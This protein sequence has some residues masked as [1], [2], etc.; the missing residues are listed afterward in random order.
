MVEAI[1][2]EAPVL[3]REVET[4]SGHLLGFA[5]LNAPKSLNAL[6]LDM[7]RLLDPQLRRW[8]EDPRVA[9]VILYGSGEKAFCAGGDIRSLHSSILKHGATPLN[10]HAL[11]FFT[12]EYG[13]DYRIHTYAKPV[14]VWASGICMGGGIGLL[15]GASHRVVTETTRLAMPEISIGFF[16]DVGGSWFL[17]KMPGRMGLFVALTGISFNGRDAKVAGLADYFASSAD[18][19]ALFERLAATRWRDATGAN[20]QI[21]SDELAMLEPPA[22]ALLPA[23]NLL[24]RAETI[25]RLCAGDSLGDIVQRI[26]NV[27]GNDDW[28]QRGARTL[29][30]GSP[31]AVALTWELQRRARKLSLADVFCLELIVALQCCAH[32][33]FPEGVRALLV[34]KD[35][36]PR[37]QPDSLEKVTAEWLDGHFVTPSWPQGV[38]PLLS[39]SGAAL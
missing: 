6:S 19:D 3:F 15:A 17:R 2:G 24:Q 14:L 22:E 26:Q 4:A 10:P 37:W 8:A 21:L 33:D 20:R 39:D 16:P 12:E 5:Q 18:R 31:T 32:P 13:L 38:H 27:P 35:N 9:C 25:E 36:K 34:D 30:A 28:L 23:S 29:Q 1:P 7:V 11:A